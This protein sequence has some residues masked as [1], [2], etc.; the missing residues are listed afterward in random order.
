M[1]GVLIHHTSNAIV[2][3]NVAY[4]NG[5]TLISSGRDNSSGVTWSDGSYGYVANNISWA[6]F[7]TDYAYALFECT[8]GNKC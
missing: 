7:T 8:D 1:N 2:T 3:N 5:A 6:R 4:L